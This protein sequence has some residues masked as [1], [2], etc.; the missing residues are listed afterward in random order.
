MPERIEEL[1]PEILGSAPE[2]SQ[3]PLAPRPIVVIR[4]VSSVDKKYFDIINDHYRING[5]IGAHLE[6]ISPEDKKKKLAMY[7]GG[8]FSSSS[9]KIFSETALT[10]A[11]YKTRYSAYSLYLQTV[12]A[13][14]NNAVV[15]FCNEELTM[16]ENT[17]VRKDNCDL[18]Y[19]SVVVDVFDYVSSG[20]QP[21]GMQIGLGTTYGFQIAPIVSIS[22]AS[23][24][25][26]KTDGLLMAADQLL[27]LT[28]A[29]SGVAE[30]A[31]YASTA[32]VV[33][34][35]NKE[36][37]WGSPNFKSMESLLSYNRPLRTNTVLALPYY[38]YEVDKADQ[39][40]SQINASRIY[41]F[42]IADAVNLYYQKNAITKDFINR[43]RFY[44]TA[45]A[46]KLESGSQLN[47]REIKHVAIAR[48]LIDK[49]AEFYGK[50]QKFI[51]EKI[52]T[53]DYGEAILKLRE[54]EDSHLSKSNIMAIGGL[55]LAAVAVNTA[56]PV[57]SIGDA[58]I[59]HINQMNDGFSSLQME[60]AQASEEIILT[61]D[62][63]SYTIVA[64]KMTELRDKLK[65]IYIR[66]R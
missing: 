5:Y 7:R 54:S 12:E 51:V 2:I 49:E 41:T 22:V 39:R 3:N 8:A 38:A 10:E 60:F 13:L 40:G 26:P 36:L 47:T 29:P 1:P 18:P 50:R 62:N 44:D 46:E 4:F 16:Q 32:S 45:L 33:E 64:S 23:D 43:V 59:D 65:K 53:S 25:S 30:P 19:A 56:T 37:F 34:L 24:L 57:Y 11:I 14:R 31:M 66:K 58:T 48:V 61:L 55:F 6:P 63:K 52:M 20:F 15:M 27:Y 21:G 28:P 17:V 35:I 9:T 42:C